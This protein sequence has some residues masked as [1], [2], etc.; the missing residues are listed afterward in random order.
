M[1]DFKLN[2]D[3]DTPLDMQIYEFIKIEIEEGQIKDEKL[4]LFVSELFEKNADT[5][6]IMPAAKLM[7]HNYVGGL[8]VHTVECVEFAELNMAS[9][10]YKANEDEIYAACLLHDF[11]K[12][13]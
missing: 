2:P 8:L 4:H 12:I 9:F 7:H 5:F 13:C 3:I 6:K 1:K 10:S 11:G